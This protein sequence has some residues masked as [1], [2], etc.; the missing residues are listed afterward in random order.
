M[1]L[2]SA[3]L[4]QFYRDQRGMSI[5][6]FIGTKVLSIENRLHVYHIRHQESKCFWY[7][8]ISQ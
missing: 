7:K 8:H 4:H 6:I 2:A 1:Q 5:S 3:K